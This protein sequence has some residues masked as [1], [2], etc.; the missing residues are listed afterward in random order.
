MH[1]FCDFDGTISIEDATDVILT[2]F[3]D[4][5]WLL[6]EEEWKAGH[7]GSAECM[8][9]QISLIRA[10]RAELA[11]ALDGIAIDPGF[12][13][14]IRFCKSYE[15]PV[16]VISDGVDYFIRHILAKHHVTD[17]P[18]IANQLIIEGING[19]TAYELASPFSHPACASA[20]GVCKCRNISSAGMRIY[21]GDGRSDFC[22]SDKPDLVFAK[23]KLA[24]YCQQQDIPYLPYKNFNDVVHGLK[25][26]LPEFNHAA[27]GTPLYAFA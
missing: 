21:V 22:V 15:L 2:R 10:S 6:I 4:P 14:F 16:T 25:K 26:A 7:I 17:L 3:A 12:A 11:E 24:I 18:V 8:R 27:T 9:R 5:Q 23:G 20:A 19:H 1:I 13:S